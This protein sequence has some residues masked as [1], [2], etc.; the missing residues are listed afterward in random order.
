VTVDR[1]MAYGLRCE[2]SGTR[3]ESFMTFC[4]TLAGKQRIKLRFE[5][6]VQFSANAAFYQNML[7]IIT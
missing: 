7:K 5:W 1:A 3:L 2:R 6:L 4:R